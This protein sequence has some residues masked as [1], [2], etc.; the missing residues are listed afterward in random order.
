MKKILITL[1]LFLSLVLTSC[2]SVDL[3]I[4][5]NGNWWNGDE[6]LGIVA[7]GPQGETGATGPQGSQG[8]TGET[9]ATGP[10]GPQGETGA[11]GPQGPQGETGATGPQGPQGEVGDTPVIGENG[12]WWVGGKDTG[13]KAEIEN[14]DRVGTDGLLFRTTIRGGVAGYEVYSYVGTATDIIIPNYIF[15]QPV[16]SIAQGALPTSITSVSISSNTEWLPCFEGYSLTSF[17][18][19]SAPIDTTTVEMF[20]DCDNLKKIENYQN[21]RVISDY[22][23]YGTQVVDFDFSNI[24]HIGSYAFY[25][26]VSDSLLLNQSFKLFL[27]IPAN[28]VQIGSNAFDSDLAVY[29]A[30]SSCTY[31]S[32]LLY[33][34]VKHTDDGYYYIDNDSGVSIVNYDGKIS[35][36]AIPRSIDGKSVTAIA[37]YAF[38]TNPYVERV[39][40]PSSVKTVGTAT[41][42]ACKNLYGIFVPNSVE[43]FGYWDDDWHYLQE[44][45][46][47]NVT[48]F[49]EATSFDYPGGITSPEQLE[50]IKYMIGIKP[51]DVIDDE[52]CVYVK[53]TLSYEVVTIKNVAGVVTIPSSINNL[54]VSRINTYAMVG[55]TLTRVVSISDGIDKI[56]TMAFYDNDYLQIVNIPDSVDAVN[57]R[58][59]YSLSSCHI[60]IEASKIPA[61]WDSSWYSSINGYTLNSQAKYDSTGSYL[62]EEVNGNVYLTKYL[63]AISTQ[64]PIFVP[65]KVDGMTVYGIKSYCYQ[66]SV[67]NSSTNKYIF[68][69]PATITDVQE[70]AIYLYRYGYCDIYIDSDSVPATWDSYWYYTSYG[71]TSY[72]TKYYK[73]QWEV[74]DGVPVAKK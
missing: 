19:N 58:A 37:D 31:S 39:E 5:E 42:F 35:R 45:G 49:F 13:V 61:D 23:F 27:Y 36:I 30:G 55:N 62:Y 15:D 38:Y 14:M 32:E 16:V 67:T 7:Q 72:A 8:E 25:E 68:V 3:Y 10:Q 29:Y 12:N 46:F 70:Y 2:S 47:E 18:F 53:K 69:I 17:D 9:G 63:K 11:T 20:S 52:V 1:L 24:T 28:V 65:E 66:S 48:V 43:S 22:T 44:Y 41:F 40:I 73:G 59:F 71:Y 51:A 50:I 74:V 54:P 6:D 33:K 4:G 60:Y 26:T 34:N 64:N 21:L 57:Y 56:S